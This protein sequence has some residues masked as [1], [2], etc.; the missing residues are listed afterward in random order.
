MALLRLPTE[1]FEQIIGE[2]AKAE[3]DDLAAS[4]LV[5]HRLVCHTFNTFIIDNIC[6]QEGRR[7]LR[8]D[9]D[10]E[11]MYRLGLFVTEILHWK[12]VHGFHSHVLVWSVAVAAN[13]LVCSRGKLSPEAA[14]SLHSEYAAK[15]CEVVKGFGFERLTT[16]V[17]DHEGWHQMS[18]YHMRCLAGAA[19]EGFKFTSR[20]LGTLRGVLFDKEFVNPNILEAVVA[21]NQAHKVHELLEWI[22]N[23]VRDKKESGNWDEMRNAGRV[24]AEAL[25][26]AI[27]MSRDKMAF[28]IIEYLKKYWHPLGRSI[29]WSLVGKMFEDCLEHGNTALFATILFWQRSGVLPESPGPSMMFTITKGEFCFVL[30]R[31]LPI[32]IRHILKTR[33]IDPNMVKNAERPFS[34]ETALWLALSARNYKMAKVLVDEGAD[35]DHVLPG[36]KNSA[37]WQAREQGN[38]DDQ[39]HLLKWGAD[40][41]PMVEHGKPWSEEDKAITHEDCLIYLRG[42][43]RKEFRDWIVGYRRKRREDDDWYY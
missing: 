28:T 12:V 32:L 14:K 8:V 33:M 34:G 6:A 26:V 35:I 40:F 30:K 23:N 21:A 43:S 31:G 22:R 42:H 9:S 36:T 2:L 37:Y 10:T 1:I 20:D 15:L 19:N 7:K 4:C 16:L 5:G 41:R 3:S 17:S 27:R 13:E 25:R 24:I 38:G 11:H 39:Y 18:P 29:N